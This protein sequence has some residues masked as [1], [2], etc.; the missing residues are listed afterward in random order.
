LQAEIKH[1]RQ[2]IALKDQTLEEI[3]KLVNDS[4]SQKTAFSSF[5]IVTKS[6]GDAKINR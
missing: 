2:A 6:L 1:L 3:R 4:L 5:D